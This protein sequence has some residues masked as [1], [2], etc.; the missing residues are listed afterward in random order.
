M[1]TLWEERLS[2]P[3]PTLTGR[4]WLLIA[5]LTPVLS[6]YTVM[7]IDRLRGRMPRP[8]TEWWRWLLPVVSC[9]TVLLAAMVVLPHP[10]REGF[11]LRIITPIFL[12]LGAYVLIAIAAVHMAAMVFALTRRGPVTS[13]SQLL[14]TAPLLGWTALI[15][16]LLASVPAG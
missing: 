3:F 15:G 9:M 8:V 1:I 16:G 13:R 2:K 14:V 4:I 10:D 7:L 12:Y 6:F 5:T 11:A